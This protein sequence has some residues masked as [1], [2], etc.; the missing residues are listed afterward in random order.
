LLGYE[1]EEV[2]GLN[3]C[4]IVRQD[5]QS[6]DA[7]VQRV[8]ACGRN[9]LGERQYIRKDGS[10]V[11]VEVSANLII[12]SG[13]RMICAVAR[14]ITERKRIEQRLQKAEAQYRH[15]WSRFQQ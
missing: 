7:N 12:F 13:R 11:D 14:D 3:V 9:F 8:L 15:F 10:L 5:R 1:I 6:V 2:T 4:D